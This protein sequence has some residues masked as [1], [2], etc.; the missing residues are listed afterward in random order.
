MVKFPD[1]LRYSKEHEWIRIDGKLATVGITEYAADQLG[2]V[3]HI[4]LPD[5]ESEFEK[6]DSCSSIESVKSV[7]DIYLPVGGKIMAVNEILT[8]NPAI[9]NEDPFGEGWILKVEMGS[10]GEVDTLMSA[11]DYEKFIS[12]E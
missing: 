12:E 11:Q 5:L 9:V 2:D 7:S 3:V 10:P 6:G 8:E 4:E 1:E